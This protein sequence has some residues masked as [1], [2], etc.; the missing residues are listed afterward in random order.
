MK[1]YIYGREGT[2]HRTT[3]LN[4]EADKKTGKVVS[5]WFRCLPLPFDIYKV[6][7]ERSNEMKKMYKRNKQMKIN[8]IEIIEE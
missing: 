5:I 4:I 8:A 6:D 1:K 7:K 3:L 2:I